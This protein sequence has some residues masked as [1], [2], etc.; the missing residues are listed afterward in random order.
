MP[1][2]SRDNWGK[3]YIM[4]RSSAGL[5]LRSAATTTGALKYINKALLEF[6][7]QKTPKALPLPLLGALPEH[8][9]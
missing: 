6:K 2:P 8:T 7:N 4:I 1:K 3:L 9:G 5:A